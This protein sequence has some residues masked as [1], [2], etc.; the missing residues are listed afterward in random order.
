[1]ELLTTLLWILVALFV[2]PTL[3]FGYAK[4]M[5]EPAKI[6]KFATWGY[7]MK[8]M[9]VIGVIEIIGAVSILFPELRLFGIAIWAIILS[10][11]VFTNLIHREPK[12][13]LFTQ[14]TV[15]AHLML[16][17]AINVWLNTT[18]K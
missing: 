6:R 18:I 3:Y 17:L 15:L 5:A 12:K 14:L 11:G 7:S 2:G 8:I 9:Q 10:G 4:M 1:M 13:E 16:I